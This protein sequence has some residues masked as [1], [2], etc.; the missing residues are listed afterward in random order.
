[1]GQTDV[2]CRQAQLDLPSM[3]M[4]REGQRNSVC[5]CLREN[6]GSVRQQK[7]RHGAIQPIQSGV[8][9]GAA[10]SKVVAFA[11]DVTKPVGDLAKPGA[12]WPWK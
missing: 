8:K 3:V 1:M 5:G 2:S 9:I 6:L 4:A 10:G 7:D 12:E 11:G